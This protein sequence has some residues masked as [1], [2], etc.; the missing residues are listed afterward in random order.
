MQCRR[1]GGGAQ[2]PGTVTHRKYSHSVSRDSQKR[3]KERESAKK[4]L[5]CRSHRLL[6][7]VLID[8]DV[9]QSLN[10]CLE[11]THG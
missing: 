11:W 6:L 7:I 3:N 4:L 1:G 5:Y 2:L 9:E 8:A 10:D